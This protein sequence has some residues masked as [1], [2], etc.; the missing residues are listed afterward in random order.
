MR[1]CYGRILISGIMAVLAISLSL[2]GLA[3]VGAVADASALPVAPEDVLSPAEFGRTI[4]DFMS[5]C[6]GHSLNTV[7]GQGVFMFGGKNGATGQASSDLWRFDPATQKWR[8]V[9]PQSSGPGSRANHAAT[10]LNNQLY[11]LGGEN[12]AGQKLAD[13]W[14]YDPATRTWHEVS[15]ETPLPGRSGHSAT[16]YNGQIFTY[17]GVLSPSI[18][19][20]ANNTYV[21]SPISGLWMKVQTQ[22][23]DNPQGARLGHTAGVIGNQL[24]LAGGETDSGEDFFQTI[25]LD[26]YPSDYLTPIISGPRPERRKNHGTVFSYTQMIVM[27]GETVTTTGS[28][29]FSDTWMFD[30]KTSRWTRLP[31]LPKPMTSLKTAAFTTTG[32][33]R[34]ARPGAFADGFKILIVGGFDD[35]DQ[36]I[37]QSYIFDGVTY[38]V[39]E[40]DYYAVFLPLILRE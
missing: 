8:R 33:S 18:S 22:W 14:R 26:N 23:G 40:M 9:S 15:Q 27:G 28:G 10:V 34:S 16:T 11:V 30:S 39:V 29:K 7:P 25:N 6:W 12:Q 31:D 32:S 2:V 38:E 5:G 13:V 36:P 20:F 21:F 37:T 24:Y 19:G 35:Q 4:T 17:G 1:S 3:A